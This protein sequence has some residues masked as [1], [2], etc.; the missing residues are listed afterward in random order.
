MYKSE[1]RSTKY[2]TI[3]NAQNTNVQNGVL[4]L[5]NLNLGF[6]SGFGFRISSFSKVVLVFALI[7]L[8]TTSAFCMGYHFLSK[9]EDSKVQ[10]VDADTGKPIEG[11]YVAVKWTKERFTLALAGAVHKV[12][13]VK[14]RRTDKDGFFKPYD[15]IEKGSKFTLVVYKSS[16]KAYVQRGKPEKEKIPVLIKLKKLTDPQERFNNVFDLPIVS[17][18][19]GEQTGLEKEAHKERRFLYEKYKIY[20]PTE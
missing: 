9:A 4:D 8:T 3:S 17:K 18:P 6:V 14:E 2:E 15:R 20:S 7:F 19:N 16:Y 1:A 11:A 13:A 5:E 10:V 12:V